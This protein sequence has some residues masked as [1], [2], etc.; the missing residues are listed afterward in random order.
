MVNIGRGALPK[1][2]CIDEFKF[3]VTKYNKYP[4]VLSDFFSGKIIDII[5]SRIEAYLQEYFSKISQ[6][7][8][9]KVKYFSSDL[10][11]PYRTIKRK[12]FPDA[13]HIVDYFHVSKLFTKLVNTMRIRVMK[14]LSTNSAEYL[15]KEFIEK[16]GEIIDFKEKVNRIVR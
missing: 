11:E 14:T 7:E 3:E 13:I 5:E 9:N 8:L 15:L 12:V 4:C 1:C 10:F 2:L 6:S 16:D